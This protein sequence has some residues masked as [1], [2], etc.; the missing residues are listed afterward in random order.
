MA[1]AQVSSA[2]LDTC[3]L[4]ILA[5]TPGAP[6]RYAASSKPSATILKSHVLT[7]FDSPAGIK[8]STKS[9]LLTVDGFPGKSRT[10]ISLILLLPECFTTFNAI[11]S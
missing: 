9:V 6:P 2:L 1:N 11:L 7:G 8:S 10:F 5:L 3:Q 4:Y